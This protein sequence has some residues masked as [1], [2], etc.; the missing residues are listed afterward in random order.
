MNDANYNKT[1]QSKHYMCECDI[2]IMMYHKI[3]YYIKGMQNAL[4]C[5]ECKEVYYN[6]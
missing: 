1:L 2:Y 4:V 3:I 6:I 5:N